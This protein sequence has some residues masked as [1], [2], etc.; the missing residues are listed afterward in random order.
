MKTIRPILTALLVLGL[1]LPLAAEVANGQPAPD[2]TLKDAAGNE[3]KLSSY[4][5]KTVVLEWTNEECPFVQHHYNDTDTM[6]KLAKSHPDVVWLAIDS[7]ANRTPAML[8]A[9]IEKEKIPYPV[10][11]DQDGSV[12]K[13]YEAKTTPHL[14][15]ISPEG[16]VVYQGAIDNDPRGRK[17]TKQNFVEKALTELEG[18]KPVTEAKTKPYGCSIKYQ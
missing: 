2:F 6:I 18:G 1:S 5:G 10:L 9:W 8:T 3:H 7:S 11:S 12:G 13:L 4:K 17:K 15:I 16:N 14:F